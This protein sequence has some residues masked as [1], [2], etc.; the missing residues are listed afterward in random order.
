ME[1]EAREEQ[2]S[3]LLNQSG[4]SSPQALL[5]AL[6]NARLIPGRDLVLLRAKRS[7]ACLIEGLRPR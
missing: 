3:G 2:G 5:L 1:C 6:G 7:L 4:A